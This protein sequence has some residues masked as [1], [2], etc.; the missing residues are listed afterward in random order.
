MQFNLSSPQPDALRG[1]EP[2]TG[3]VGLTERGSDMA[4]LLEKQS[5]LINYLRDHNLRLNQ[6][7][8][9][10]HANM[11]QNVRQNLNNH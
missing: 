6:K 4:E 7:L 2:Y 9:Q 5:D 3:S 10:L 8:M 1:S 11:S